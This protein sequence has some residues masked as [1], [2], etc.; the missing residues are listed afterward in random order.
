MRGI[1]TL[2]PKLLGI[3][4]P[5]EHEQARRLDDSSAEHGFLV[6]QNVMVLF[7]NSQANSSAARTPERE[8]RDPGARQDGEIMS[9]EGRKQIAVDHAE[10]LT[11]LRI[12]VHITR[13]ISY[14]RTDI[15]DN[16]MPQ[17]LAR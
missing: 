8:H 9:L 11:I 15:L 6:G 17:C 14:R 4:D 1:S 12:E 5:R 7:A 3:A 10:A 2:S 13:P 16:P